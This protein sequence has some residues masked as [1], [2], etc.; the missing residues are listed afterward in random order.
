[1][2]LLKSQSL[3]PCAMFAVPE[4]HPDASSESWLPFA[5]P[6][7]G[8]A[9]TMHGAQGWTALWLAARAKKL[10]CTGKALLSA[11]S[12][13]LACPRLRA[14]FHTEERISAQVG[15]HKLQQY[16]QAAGLPVDI[17]SAP[18]VGISCCA[19]VSAGQGPVQVS[20]ALPSLRLIC[21]SMTDVSLGL[22]SQRR[23]A[24]LAFVAEL[25]RAWTSP[26]RML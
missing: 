26:F 13:C 4:Q 1:M 18:E 19:P 24:T 20:G 25:G 23:L 22:A 21:S 16:R 15:L 8:I 6:R 3:D 9:F 17:L 14:G 10:G 7:R 12:T 11:A 5:E 2:Q